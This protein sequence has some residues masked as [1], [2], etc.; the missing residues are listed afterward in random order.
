MMVCFGC[1][2]IPDVGTTI[3]GRLYCGNATEVNAT[4][5]IAKQKAERQKFL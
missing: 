2:S 4:V 5:S 1:D 3:L